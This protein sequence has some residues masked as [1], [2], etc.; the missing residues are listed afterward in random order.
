MTVEKI[1]A[2]KLITSLYRYER[3]ESLFKKRLE[4]INAR[5]YIQ[6]G[7]GEDVPFVHSEW[8]KYLGSRSVVEYEKPILLV[9]QDIF[10][11]MAHLLARYDTVAR[12]AWP[13][14][15]GLDSDLVSDV[16]FIYHNRHAYFALDFCT[17]LY[18]QALHF[19]SEE[20]N[21]VNILRFKGYIQDITD[22]PTRVRVYMRRLS[23]PGQQDTVRDSD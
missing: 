13:V 23:Y 6:L 7:V 16:E 17:S 15:A 19:S 18:R 9:S 21:N 14:S 3:F 8:M 20:Y 12:L 5:G 11:E 2:R 4:L 1:S 22:H 10:G